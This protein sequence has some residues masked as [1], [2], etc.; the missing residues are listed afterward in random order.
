MKGIDATAPT[1]SQAFPAAIMDTFNAFLT[2]SIFKHFKYSREVL[3]CTSWSRFS[4]KV[5]IK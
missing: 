1:F 3:N 2:F 5:E 4:I